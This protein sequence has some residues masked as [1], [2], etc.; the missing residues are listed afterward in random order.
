MKPFLWVA[1]AFLLGANS[2]VVIAA[3]APRPPHAP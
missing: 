3:E 2:A 1:L